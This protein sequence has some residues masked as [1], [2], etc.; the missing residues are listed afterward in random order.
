MGVGD[1]SRRPRDL[2]GAQSKRG[3]RVLVPAARATVAQLDSSRAHLDRAAVVV[4]VPLDDHLVAAERGRRL[5]SLKEVD[6]REV[7]DH[8]P[9]VDASRVDVTLPHVTAGALGRIVAHRTIE[10]GEHLLDVERLTELAEK[11]DRPAV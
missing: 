10:D 4:V 11:V 7:G 9:G 8:A 1:R 3:V 5:A 2:E 6:H